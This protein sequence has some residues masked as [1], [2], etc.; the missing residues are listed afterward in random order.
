MSTEVTAGYVGNVKCPGVTTQEQLQYDEQEE[1]KTVSNSKCVFATTMKGQ[2]KKKK[3]FN[4][5]KQME[6]LKHAH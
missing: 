1:K 4:T 2:K 5:V 3:G 6:G